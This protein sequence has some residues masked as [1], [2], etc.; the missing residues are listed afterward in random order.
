MA[1]KIQGGVKIPKV[2]RGHRPY[3][4]VTKAAMKLKAGQSFKCK[5]AINNAHANLVTAKR[6]SGF[7]FTVRSES[8]G[9]RI[10]RI[11]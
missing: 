10:W 4:E 7:T 2:I 5:S 11:K 1:I 8:K 3:T 6:L 9:C